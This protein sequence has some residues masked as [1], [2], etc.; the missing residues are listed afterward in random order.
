M[1]NEYQSVENL[2]DGV[3]GTS[4]FLSRL[5]SPKPVLVIFLAFLGII[6]VNALF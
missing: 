4:G 5:F 3:K 2:I 1:T 6:V